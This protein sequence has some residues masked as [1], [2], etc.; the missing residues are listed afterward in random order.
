[1]FRFTIRDV[2][3]LTALAALAVSWWLDHRIT[4]ERARKAQFDANTTKRETKGRIDA[5]EEQVM[6]LTQHL[7]LRDERDQNK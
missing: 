7:R 4:T 1:M 3:W 6:A 5:L 2:L